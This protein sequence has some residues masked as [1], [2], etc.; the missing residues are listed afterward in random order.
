M[1]ADH[2]PIQFDSNLVAGGIAGGI[3]HIGSAI[4]NAIPQHLIFVVIGNGSDQFD[5]R[6]DEFVLIASNQ[7]VGNV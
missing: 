3:N 6:F 7:F 1:A 5:H 4:W 2:V